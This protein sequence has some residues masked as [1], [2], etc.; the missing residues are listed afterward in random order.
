MSRVRVSW[1]HGCEAHHNGG[2][3]VIHLNEHQRWT[4]IIAVTIIALML[5]FPHEGM[6]C[7]GI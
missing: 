1:A 5:L 3:A 7:Y 4:L 6:L 2:E